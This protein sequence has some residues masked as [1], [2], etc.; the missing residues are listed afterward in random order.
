[1]TKLENADKLRM[2]YIK[3]TPRKNIVNI[4]H[5]RPN[6]NGCDYCDIYAG[7]GL[8]CW[9]QTKSHWC[10]YCAEVEMRATE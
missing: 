2:E 1:M 4:C 6:W 7:G 8:E 10:C 5:A 9:E 3:N